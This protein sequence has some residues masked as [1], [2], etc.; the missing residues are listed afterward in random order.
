MKR[1]TLTILLVF[2]LLVGFSC[3]RRTPTEAWTVPQPTVTPPV[4]PLL[5]P[6]SYTPYSPATGNNYFGLDLYSELR[7]EDGNI[8]FSPFSIFSALS[9]TGEGARDRTWD[10]MRSVLHLQEDDHVRR[11]AFLE[12]ISTINAPG[13]TYQ[14]KTANNLWLEQTKEFYPDYLNITQDYYLAELTNLDFKNNPEGSRITINDRV[15]QQTEG[16]ITNLIPQGGITSITRLVL[17]NA[18]YFLAKWR[19]EFLPNKTWAQDFDLS[20]GDT[21]KVDMMH[22]EL[23]GTIEDYHGVARVL[24]LPYEGDE[25]S[26]FIFLP[27]LGEM[28]E[29]EDNMTIGQLDAWMASRSTTQGSIKIALALPKFKVETTYTM[30]NILQDMG[31]PYA[32]SSKNADFSGM[33]ETYPEKLYITQVIHKAFVEV[34]EQGTEAAA[35]TAVIIGAS[36][37]T[38]VNIYVP[39]VPFV[40]DHPFIF[41]ICENSTGAILF[42]GRVNEL[43]PASDTGNTGNT[44]DTGLLLPI[45]S[46]IP[47]W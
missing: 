41:T 47:S 6:L 4:E 7:S 14:L 40:V 2:T 22:Q 27:E 23:R 38:S 35:A 26:M 18:I 11:N 33:A 32:F 21:I 44:G 5:E 34:D 3:K 46:L 15:A 9:M 37:T 29:L 39:P 30:S 25:V 28:A 8:F 31:M 17:T 12:L 42:M 36:I 43:D 16:K 13:K 45:G 24:E 20:P 19:N 10:E 1:G